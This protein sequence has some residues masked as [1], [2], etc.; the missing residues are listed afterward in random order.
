MNPDLIVINDISQLKFVLS[1]NTSDLNGE[2]GRRRGSLVS[3]NC[4]C[5]KNDV[6]NDNN[7]N[8]NNNNDDDSEDDDDDVAVEDN[9]ICIEGTC[10]F[11]I[12]CEPYKEFREKFL[13]DTFNLKSGSFQEKWESFD[14]KR[15]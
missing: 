1:G 4:N 14:E 7:N 10:H 11:L 6:S 9:L 12:S 8:N 15:K 13:I 3:R 2:R 5:C